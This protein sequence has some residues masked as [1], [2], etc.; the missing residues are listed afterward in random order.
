M[1]YVTV[2]EVATSPLWPVTSQEIG[3]ATRALWLWLLLPYGEGQYM[4]S[5]S[6][7]LDVTVPWNPYLTYLPHHLKPSMNFPSC[8][9]LRNASSVASAAADGK[10]GGLSNGLGLCFW[11]NGWSSYN[12]SVISLDWAVMDHVL[13]FSYLLTL[14][15]FFLFFFYDNILTSLL[16]SDILIMTLLHSTPLWHHNDIIAPLWLTYEPYPWFLVLTFFLEGY[17]LIFTSSLDHYRSPLFS[18]PWFHVWP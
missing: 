15:L 3:N 4:Q 2:S 5:P 14:F 7:H 12:V 17:P 11:M 18:K 6:H 1:L 13:W 10:S 16:H 9:V 8:S